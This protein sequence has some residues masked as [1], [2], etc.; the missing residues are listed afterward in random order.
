[1]SQIHMKP[2][3]AAGRARR[4]SVLYHLCRIQGFFVGPLS[5]PWLG[6]FRAH[7]SVRISTPLRLQSFLKLAVGP[8]KKKRIF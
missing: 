3:R 6:C 7:G 5:N 8:V 1:M 2:L 4:P